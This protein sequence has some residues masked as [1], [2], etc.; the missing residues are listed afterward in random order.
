[1]SVSEKWF[2]GSV[3]RRLTG[4]RFRRQVPIGPYFLDFYAP[5][6][7]VCV[8]VDGEQHRHSIV[9]DH[10]RD[11]FLEDRGILTIRIPSLDL[12][13]KDDDL[14]SAWIEHVQSVCQERVS[15]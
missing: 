2:W 9:R 7:K 15:R 3:R 1:M 4:F 12:F 13:Y 10:I 14:H 8:E 5:Q 6:A 11:K